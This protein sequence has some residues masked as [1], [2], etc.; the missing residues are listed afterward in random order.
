MGAR[1]SYPTP[2]G[3]DS[4]P[5]RCCL[6]SWGDIS[7]RI[8]SGIMFKNTSKV[9][10]DFTTVYSERDMS[11]PICRQGPCGLGKRGK[12]DASWLGRRR[13]SLSEDEGLLF[14]SKAHI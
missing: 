2:L 1:G 5:L 11:G 7:A 4:L 3:I 12:R 14:A 13:R 9:Y 10:H 6:D 8:S